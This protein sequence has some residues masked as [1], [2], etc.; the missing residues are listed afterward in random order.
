MNLFNLDR[1]RGDTGIILTLSQIYV[2]RYQLILFE[3]M[4]ILEDVFLFILGTVFGKHPG[5]LEEVAMWI[6]I[7]KYE[8]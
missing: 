4:Q 1:H 7:F 2:N 3:H 6:Y 8:F 5:M